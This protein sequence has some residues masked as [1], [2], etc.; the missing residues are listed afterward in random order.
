M[1]W[2]F[3]FYMIHKK[4]T[5][6]SLIISCF[7]ISINKTLLGWLRR[8]CQVVISSWLCI[9]NNGPWCVKSMTPCLRLVTG[10]SILLVSH[11]LSTYFFLTKNDDDTC[12]YVSHLTKYFG[13]WSNWSERPDGIVIK[14][15]DTYENKFGKIC[16]FGI[17]KNV[18]CHRSIHHTRKISTRGSIRIHKIGVGQ[19]VFTLKDDWWKKW[20]LFQEN[21]H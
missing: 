21:T 13:M 20:V 16:Y 5:H 19:D 12:R 1:T 2:T 10:T 9:Y 3:P 4:K 14:I 17:Q 15:Q 8:A 7:S 6:E 18:G 11:L